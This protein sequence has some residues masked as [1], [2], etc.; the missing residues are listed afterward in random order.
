VNRFN[1]ANVFSALN[2]M[3]KYDN[4][5]KLINSVLSQSGTGLQSE[6]TYL[7]EYSTTSLQTLIS[8]Y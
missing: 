3:S 2:R 5:Y 6:I 8:F 7:I 4:K 1:P